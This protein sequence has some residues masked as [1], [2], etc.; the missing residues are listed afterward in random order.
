MPEIQPSLCWM[1]L[2][3]YPYLE[4]AW[5]TAIPILKV[6][7]LEPSLSWMRLKYSHPYFEC[8]FS[9]ILILNVP[10]Q[11]LLYWMCLF[12]HPYIECAWFRVCIMHV[13]QGRWGAA[14]LHPGTGR[15]PLPLLAPL[16]PLARPLRLPAGQVLPDHGQTPAQDRHGFS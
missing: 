2:F 13:L 3:S 9:S 12:S 14:L 8:A 16:L 1:C 15:C 4:C 10:F 5:I 11:P 7:K 6:P